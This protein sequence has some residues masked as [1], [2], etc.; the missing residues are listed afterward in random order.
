MHP[1]SELACQL[2]EAGYSQVLRYRDAVYYPGTDEYGDPP[3]VDGVEYIR[4][5]H[6]TDTLGLLEARKIA[7]TVEACP[8]QR[9]PV[10]YWG[11]RLR[12]GDLVFE[13]ASFGAVVQKL[14][15]ALNVR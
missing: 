7:F 6:A 5:P 4:V 2:K 10:S 12:S 8:V 13:D 3:A 11:Y 14:W 9:G 15:L 1:Y